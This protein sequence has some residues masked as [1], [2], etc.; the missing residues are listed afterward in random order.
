MR[1]L[2]GPSVL[3]THWGDEYW[4][5]AVTHF[6]RCRPVLLP[7]FLKKDLTH[8]HSRLLCG[9]METWGSEQKNAPL[10]TPFPGIWF[11]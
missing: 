10:P 6:S 11:L 4:R 8:T 2:L 1:C 5:Q 9:W 3:E 7:S